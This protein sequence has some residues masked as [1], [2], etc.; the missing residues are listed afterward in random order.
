MPPANRSY[1]ASR[2]ILEDQER[3]KYVRTANGELEG[4]SG[5]RPSEAHQRHQASNA[6]FFGQG[7][8]GDQRP[9]V[10]GSNGQ[11]Q[12]FP[13][14]A[15][16]GTSY[17]PTWKRLQDRYGQRSAQGGFPQPTASGGMI[18]GMPAN[19][20][21]ANSAMGAGRAATLNPEVRAIQVDPRYGGGMGYA[22]NAGLFP[23]TPA[24]QATQRT[25]PPKPKPTAA[26]ARKASPISYPAPAA[27]ASGAVQQA[28]AGMSAVGNMMG[29]ATAKPKGAAGALTAMTPQQPGPNARRK[30]GARDLLA[31]LDAIPRVRNVRQ[32]PA[33]AQSTL[34][35]QRERRGGHSR[36]CDGLPDTNLIYGSL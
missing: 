14:P 36:P 23:A 13:S 16:Q 8:S 26:E 10:T 29:L 20:A 22:G 12:H 21:I 31:Y 7:Q 9:A 28:G 5:A 34:G 32:N 33:N 2:T 35:P 1:P 4:V 18:N 24:P 11:I 15:Q 6:A 17:V 19:Q 30:Q 3:K 27:M 25:A